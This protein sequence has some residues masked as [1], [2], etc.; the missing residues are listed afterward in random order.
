MSYAAASTLDFW[1]RVSSESGYDYLEL[2]IDG[3][4]QDSWSGTV[5]WTEASYPLAAGAHTIEWRYTKDSSISSGDDAAWVD[6]I[7]L[8]LPPTTGGLCPP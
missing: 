2:W 1:Y 8:G 4:Q 3:S 5:G 7:D 6:D